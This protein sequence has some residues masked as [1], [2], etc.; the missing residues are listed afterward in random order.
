[1]VF[2]NVIYQRVLGILMSCMHI[3]NTNILI[4]T[5]KGER[6]EQQTDF[7][8]VVQISELEIMPEFPMHT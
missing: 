2:L 1:M 5:E 8:N 4:S 7:K 6:G 3:I